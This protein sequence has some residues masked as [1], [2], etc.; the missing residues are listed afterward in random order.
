MEIT[1]EYGA[2]TQSKREKVWGIIFRLHEEARKKRPRSQIQGRR[3]VG[4]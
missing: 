4:A 3:V 1:Q 2:V